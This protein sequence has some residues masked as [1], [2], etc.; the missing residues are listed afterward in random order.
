MY[1]SHMVP[2]ALHGGDPLSMFK[3]NEY[4]ARVRDDF[5]K[6]GFFENLVDKHLL[7]NKHYLK[8]KYTPDSSKASVEE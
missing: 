8:L 3:I 1:I 6:G 2:Y 5:S 4:S 7:N